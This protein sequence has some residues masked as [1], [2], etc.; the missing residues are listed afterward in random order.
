MARADIDSRAHHACDGQLRRP[1]GGEPAGRYREVF[2][3]V[4]QFETIGLMILLG[5]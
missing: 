5:P 1:V 4:S 3:E 2:S